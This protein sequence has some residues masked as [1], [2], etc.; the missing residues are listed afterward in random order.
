MAFCATATFTISSCEEEIDSSNFAIK[1]EQT[2]ADIL[3]ED[4]KIKVRVYNEG[5]GISDA[6]LP[7]A[8][9]LVRPM[10]LL[11]TVYFLRAVITPL[12]FPIMLQLRIISRNL[13][14][15]TLTNSLTNRHSWWLIVV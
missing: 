9:V 11:S 10:V 2:L 6:D 7:Y 14:L 4:K 15:V 8:Y 3:D 13:R 5:Q 1:K 12:S